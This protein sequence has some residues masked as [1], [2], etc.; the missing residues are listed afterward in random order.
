[1]VRYI[2][3][4]PKCGKTVSDP[5]YDS[6]IFFCPVCRYMEF[7]EDVPSRFKKEYHKGIELGGTYGKDDS[8]HP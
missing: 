1:M 4:C 6:D 7:V 8:Y 3:T 2:V 5:L